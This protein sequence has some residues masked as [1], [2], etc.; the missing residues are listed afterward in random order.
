MTATSEVPGRFCLGGLLVVVVLL[1]AG[2]VAALEPGQRLQLYLA[3]DTEAFGVLIEVSPDGAFMLS[4]ECGE[5]TFPAAEIELVVVDP[6]LWSPPYSV[7]GETRHNPAKHEAGLWRRQ[8]L[9]VPQ[10]RDY[11]EGRMQLTDGRGRWLGPP[12]LGYRTRLLDGRRRFH[13]IEAGVPGHRLTVGEF[14]ARTGDDELVARFE[15]EHRAAEK[16]VGTGLALFG[17]GVGSIVVGVILSA[18]G[19][20]NGPGTGGQPY[21]APLIMVSIPLFVVGAIFVHKGG[22][23]LEQ[24]DGTDV[25]DLVSRGRGWSLAQEYNGELRETLGLPDDERLDAP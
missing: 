3:D 14:V 11:L 9:D 25:S 17:A 16:R 22:R 18:A 19:S 7:A 8:Y 20:P 15:F 21:G 12:T 4:T 13:V 24:L 23:R 2:P 6:E 10:Y 5:L 1:L